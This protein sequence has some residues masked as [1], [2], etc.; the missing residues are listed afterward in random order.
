[1]DPG[2]QANPQR[3]AAGEGRVR[4]SKTLN[5]TLIKALIVFK[6]QV[7]TFSQPCSYTFIDSPSSILRASAAACA[8]P[9]GLSLRQRL[10]HSL[11]EAPEAPTAPLDI[12]HTP[13][14]QELLAHRVLQGLEEEK[15]ES[16]R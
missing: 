6:E 4:S 11:L 3:E 13:T 10:F 14:A 8:A 1:M 9:T 5:E 12:T 16:N 15:V 2:H 7:V